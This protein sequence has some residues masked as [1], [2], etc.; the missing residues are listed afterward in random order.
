M[1]IGSLQAGP[2]LLLLLAAG[3]GS[4]SSPSIPPPVQ[5]AVGTTGGAVKASDGSGVTVPAGALPAN[6]TITVTPTASA[7]PPP[8]A[9]PVGTAVTFGPEGQQFAQ[10][11]TVTLSFDPSSLPSGVSAANIVVVTAPAGSSSYTPL[12]TTQVDSTHVSA[13]TTH[14]STFVATVAASG[15]DGGPLDA[16]TG[17]NAGGAGGGS[18]GGSGGSSGGGSDGGVSGG[19]D[20]GTGSPDAGVGGGGG[21]LPDGGPDDAGSESDGGSVED[22][23]QNDGGVDAGSSGDAGAVDAGFIDA[24][25]HDAGSPEDAGPGDAGSPEDAGPGDA[26]SS[27]GGLPDSGL[28][29]GCVPSTTQCVGD[30]VQSCDLSGMWEDV[31]C[32]PPAN[33]TSI[34]AAGGTCGY[35][36]TSP[37]KDC[38]GDAGNGCESNSNTDPKNCGGCNNPC[39]T[40]TCINGTCSALS[41]GPVASIASGATLVGTVF[42]GTGDFNGDHNLDLAVARQ[43]STNDVL[44]F[45][46]NGDGTFQTPVSFSAGGA[47]EMF[48]V[49]D[50]NGDGKPDLLIATSSGVNVLLGYGDGRFKTPT[51]LPTAGPAYSIAL[52]DLNNDHLPDFVV[53][54]TGGTGADGGTENIE[55]FLNTGDG[56]TFVPSWESLIQF[57]FGYYGIPAVADYNLD[58]NADVAVITSGDFHVALGNGDGTFGGLVDAGPNGSPG[59]PGGPIGGP[60]NNFAVADINLD[61]YPDLVA[62]GGYV[63]LYLN[64]ANGEGTFM[65]PPGFFTL[66]WNNTTAY[67]TSVADF[68][69]DGIPDLAVGAKYEPSTFIL[70]GYGDGTFAAPFDVITDLA[71][72]TIVVAGDFNND[73]KPDIVSLRSASSTLYFLVISLNTTPY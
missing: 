61:G 56:G 45:L 54:T 23:G 65:S 29:G 35:S 43:G 30:V 22:A 8:A 20:A 21:G 64:N 57:G 52:G 5:Q 15:S 71:N 47:P 67:F 58:G 68:N 38:D 32:T 62:T 33:A 1:R 10:P 72:V 40:G 34:C 69:G 18:G 42:V 31:A 55:A 6:V 49:S 7:P 13:Q 17:G 41:F 19:Q 36:C 50:V 28:S 25:I 63:Y 59:D 60:Y 2:M 16:G 53:M 24:G 9:T 66:P 73:G 48:V 11:V 37:Y 26:G 44:I 14:F 51:T 27:D 4:N 12:A 3:C 46:G 39:L 70:A